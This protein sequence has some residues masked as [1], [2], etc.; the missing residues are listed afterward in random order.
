MTGDARDKVEIGS[1]PGVGAHC[2]GA[3]GEDAQERDGANAAAGGAGEVRPFLRLYYQCATVYARA[4]KSPDGSCY[5]GRCPKCGLR[6]RFGI[7]PQGTGQR[8]FVM[9]CQ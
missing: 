2:A 9:T 7:G 1:T 8:S 5:E 6:T 4:Y 3:G